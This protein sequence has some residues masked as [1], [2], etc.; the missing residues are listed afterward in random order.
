MYSIPFQLAK[1]YC[2]V[3]LNRKGFLASVFLLVLLGLLLIPNKEAAYATFYIGNRI[4]YPNDFWVGSLGAVFSNIILTFIGF[5]FLEGIAQKERETGMGYLLRTSPAPNLQLLLHKWLAYTLLLLGFLLILSITLFVVNLR[6]FNAGTFATPFLYFSVPY[7]FLLASAIVLSDYLVSQRGL[8]IALFILISIVLISPVAKGLL[9]VT[10]INAFFETVKLKLQ[11]SGILDSN[12]Y[13]IGVAQKSGQYQYFTLPTFAWG[14]QLMPRLLM[15]IFGLLL[16][17]FGS[18]VFNRYKNLWPARLNKNNKPGNVAANLRATPSIAMLWNT[19]GQIEPTINYGHLF[20]AEFNL[21]YACF[22]MPQLLAIIAL[23]LGAFFVSQAIAAKILVPLIFLLLFP[24]Y[25][26][27]VNIPNA[28]NMAGSFASSVYPEKGRLAVK[29]AILGLLYLICLAPILIHHGV[30]FNMVIIYR[31]LFLS[32]LSV[33]CAQYL[34]TVK[35]FE[36][37]YLIL[38]ASYLSGSPIIALY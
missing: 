2:Q 12:K 26:R 15:P 6:D 29:I 21:F 9:D 8:K 7:V 33:I 27:Y 36:I 5:F 11:A 13:A 28:N 17:Y 18:L 31:M 19:N 14:Q 4:G 38:F 37:I 32:A 10:G 3:L 35:P 23:W 25:Q 30:A 1:T 20:R 16:I 34:K 24:L 22:R